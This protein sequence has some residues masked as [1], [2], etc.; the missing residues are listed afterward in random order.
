MNEGSKKS[1]FVAG[2]TGYTGQQ[3]VRILAEQGVDVVAH[4]R[5]DSSSLERWRE[6]F[7]GWGARVDTT[8]WEQGA[9]T[10]TLSELRPD[11]VYCLIG[12]TRARDKA[13]DEDAGYE[14]IDFGLTD[15]LVGACA[16][17]SP[18]SR[19]VYLSAMGVSASSASAYYKARWKAEESVRASGLSYIIARPGLI[20]GPDRDESRPMER[21]AGVVSG[22]IFKGLSAVGAD[23]LHDRY[24][25]TDAVELATALV[26][27]A[28]EATDDQA[29]LETPQLRCGRL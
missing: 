1:A 17:G 5:P 16:A 25:P 15:L 20:T 21:V 2:A 12:T 29:V 8:A 19:F 18:E 3:V 28:L 9:M 11:L 13:T 23:K 6:T 4:V 14:A 27:R 22:A 7:E 26:R 24:A 10:A